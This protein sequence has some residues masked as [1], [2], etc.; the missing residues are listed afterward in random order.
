MT[1][2]DKEAIDALLCEVD[3]RSIEEGGPVLSVLVVH[4]DGAV[5]S[6]FW[7]SIKKHGLRQVLESDAACVA[8]HREAALKHHRKL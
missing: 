8:R 6:A 7:K 1:E 5:S 2:F 3:D 4:D